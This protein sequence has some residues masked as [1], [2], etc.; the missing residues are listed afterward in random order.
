MDSTARQREISS[1][2]STTPLGGSDIT[3][4]AASSITLSRIS[5]LTSVQPNTTAR[6]KKLLP[7]KALFVCGSVPAEV[8]V[9]RGRSS[10]VVERRLKSDY[11]CKP[12]QLSISSAL[13][14][15]GGETHFAAA[16][17]CIAR[18]GLEP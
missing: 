14:Q 17:L 8:S 12:K 15:L 7:E 9:V 18:V 16:K 5:T 1:S 11:N 3:T 2:G 6:L 4:A 10:E 13:I